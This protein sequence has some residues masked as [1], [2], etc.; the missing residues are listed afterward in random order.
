MLS[1]YNERYRIWNDDQVF[2]AVDL[3]SSLIGILS[4]GLNSFFSKKGYRI[5][6]MKE[7]KVST[8][9]APQ[10][11]IFSLIV[12]VPV[13]LRYLFKGLFI[14][15]QVS[16]VLI[17]LF[18]IAILILSRLYIANEQKKDFF[19]NVKIREEVRLKIQFLGVSEMR[20]FIGGVLLAFILYGISITLTVVF[21]TSGS[22]LSFIGSIISILMIFLF[23]KR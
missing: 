8:N 16:K 3:D 2:Y 21:L 13:F 15:N 10:R 17:L 22:V 14:E 20:R 7:D 4:L 19:E 5:D 6:P 18:T 12:I 11:V 23:L 9:S 1:K